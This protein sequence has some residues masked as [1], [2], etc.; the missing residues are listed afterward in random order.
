MEDSIDSQLIAPLK[1]VHVENFCH[2][3]LN[4][5]AQELLTAMKTY[6]ESQHFKNLPDKN[7]KSIPV[8]YRNAN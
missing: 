2:V 1:Y 4:F 6:C 8:S 3:P 7:L 5:S